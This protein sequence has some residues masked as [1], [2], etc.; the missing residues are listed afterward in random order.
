MMQKIWF[1]NGWNPL[2]LK[3]RGGGVWNFPKKGVGSKFSDYKGG[4]RKIRG[5]SEKG[6]PLTN[7]NE[8]FVKLSFFLF[9][10]GGK[11]E[12]GGRV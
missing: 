3:E 1:Y 7:P 10:K 6:V 9:E 5:C 11:F 12:K 8:P 2:F 4:V